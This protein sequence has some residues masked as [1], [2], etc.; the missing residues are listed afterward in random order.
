MWT[1]SNFQKLYEETQTLLTWRWKYTDNYNEKYTEKY[2]GM[3]QLVYYNLETAMH[4]DFPPAN[5]WRRQ[6]KGCLKTR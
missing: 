4:N 5:K 3:W 6:Y 1:P 2:V